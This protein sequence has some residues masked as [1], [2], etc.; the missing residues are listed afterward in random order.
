MHTPHQAGKRTCEDEEQLISFNL[1]HAEGK[2]GIKTL[3]K[4][5]EIIAP[6]KIG[7]SGFAVAD[8]GEGD[9]DTE[10]PNLLLSVEP[11]KKK[12]ASK[13]PASSLNTQPAKRPAQASCEALVPTDEDRA[14]A[15]ATTPSVADSESTKQELIYSNVFTEPHSPCPVCWKTNFSK[16]K[17]LQANFSKAKLWPTKFSKAKPCRLQ[18]CAT[19]A[20]QHYPFLSQCVGMRNMCVV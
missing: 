8:F 17:L 3:K 5:N 6:L 18:C 10:C 16:T 4:G 13:R 2:V 9:E 15:T 19:W 7:K 14:L 20:A 1:S 11:I 12:P